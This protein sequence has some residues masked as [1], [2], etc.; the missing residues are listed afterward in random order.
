MWFT[1]RYC[2]WFEVA[3]PHTKTLALVR[4]RRKAGRGSGLPGI[5]RT[6]HV[7]VICIVGM[8][9]FDI[10]ASSASKGKAGVAE[11]VDG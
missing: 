3:S 9:L 2:L 7:H 5:V 8:V 6:K 10:V 4:L 1:A 11:G